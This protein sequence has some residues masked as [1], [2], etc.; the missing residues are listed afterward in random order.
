MQRV[1][2]VFFGGLSDN[3]A[4]AGL[5]KTMLVR[6]FVRLQRRLQR[7]ILREAG[8]DLVIH[9]LPWELP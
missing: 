3:G 4:G 2:G 1:L 8:E 7:N 6:F 5:G 9:L